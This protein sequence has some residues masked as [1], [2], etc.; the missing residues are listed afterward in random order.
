MRLEQDPSGKTISAETWGPGSE[1]S[2]EHAPELVGADDDD[3][4]FAVALDGPD[5]PGRSAL[6]ELRKHFMGLRMSRT[7]AVV[8]ALVPTILEQKV[9]GVEAHRAYRGLVLAFGE[10]AP[11]PA[12]V[13]A[14]LMVPPSP[15]VLASQPYWA[16]HRFGI[17][18]K[19]A[20][21]IRLVCSYASRLEK[22]AAL[23]GEDA[24]EGLMSLPGIG[25]WSAAEVAVRA[26]GDPDAVSVGDYHLPHQVAWV[27]TGAARGDDET[28][29]RLLE[30]VRGQ[31]GRAIRLIEASGKMAP[32]R[33]PRMPIRSI[34]DI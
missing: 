33:G 4:P 14:G 8:E 7:L 17:E 10:P 15:H 6:R 29:L 5:F 23:A 18:R 12:E 34:R 24:R 25:P 26:L 28:M 9:T 27:L 16:Y 22:L 20:D 2:L 21:T 11:G 3:A 1:W 30:P 32:R 31:R 13:T 19:R